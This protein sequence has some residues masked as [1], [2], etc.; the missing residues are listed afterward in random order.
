MDAISNWFYDNSYDICDT[1][2]DV[3]QKINKEYRRNR[4]DH[5]KLVELQVR[6]DHLEIRSKEIP[7]NGSWANMEEELYY[8]YFS[9]DDEN[10]AA[11]AAEEL[12][13]IGDHY[14]YEIG[15]EYEIRWPDINVPALVIQW[16]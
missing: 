9:I 5:E 10:D 13:R 16:D 8:G 3:M 7:L 1:I 11:I 2:D 14:N 12:E 4:V 15:A 6:P